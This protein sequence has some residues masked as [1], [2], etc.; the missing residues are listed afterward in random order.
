MNKAEFLKLKGYNPEEW[1]IMSAETSQAYLPEKGAVNNMYEIK[2]RK[3]IAALGGQK[4]CYI[5]K[6]KWMFDTIDIMDAE[7]RSGMVKKKE[8]PI[9]ET[10]PAPP[11]PPSI[12]KSEAVPLPPL[13]EKVDGEV[14]NVPDEIVEETKDFLCDKYEQTAEMCDEQCAF[15][16]EKELVKPNVEEI[17]AESHRAIDEAINSKKDKKALR[18]KA[19]EELGLSHFEDKYVSKDKSYGVTVEKLNTC[20]DEEFETTIDKLKA[21]IASLEPKEEAEKPK[22]D[23]VKKAQED[24]K[25]IVEA[26]GIPKENIVIGTVPKKEKPLKD[27][28]VV[29]EEVSPIEENGDVIAQIHNPSL[30]EIENKRLAEFKELE[31][32]ER[33]SVGEKTMTPKLIDLRDVFAGQALIGLFSIS[34]LNPPYQWELNELAERAYAIAD[35]MIKTR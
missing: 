35:E 21:H 34:G 33:K 25:E 29:S 23:P 19:L 7:G 8:T 31:K 17:Y 4:G 5:I 27:I 30:T 18:I 16:T 32:A 14:V 15:C 6:K 22:V 24:L 2:E 3:E 1:D 28:E 26:S 13:K 9:Q 10:T 11:P 20:T 12:P